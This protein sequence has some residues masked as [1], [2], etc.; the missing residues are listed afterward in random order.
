MMSEPR[1]F[2]RNTPEQ[3]REIARKGGAAIPA[4]KRAFSTKEGLAARAGAIGGKKSA[5]ARAARKAA[6]MK[7]Q[8]A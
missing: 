3:Q 4:E 7:E 5:E 6:L 2:A 1:G 8:S